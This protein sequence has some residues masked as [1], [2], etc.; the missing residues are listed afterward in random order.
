MT[1]KFLRVFQNPE[2]HRLRTRKTSPGRNGRERRACTRSTVKEKG[3]QDSSHRGGGKQPTPGDHAAPP[4]RLCRDPNAPEKPARAQAAG[5][6]P[7]QKSAG[8]PHT[9]RPPRI[10]IRRAARGQTCRGAA[11][12]AGRCKG[13]IYRQR[14]KSR[15]HGFCKRCPASA[16]SPPG[17]APGWPVP[18]FKARDPAIVSPRPPWSRRVADNELDSR[19]SSWGAR[20]PS[21]G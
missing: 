21:E 10:W 1:N 14:G 13:R 8:R 12:F 15:S 18:P 17:S 5:R 20:C 16:A 4:S 2:E 9:A 7:G 11:G 19:M 6:Y 3:T